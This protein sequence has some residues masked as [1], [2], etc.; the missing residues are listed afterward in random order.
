MQAVAP[1]GIEKAAEP[2]DPA[3]KVEPRKLVF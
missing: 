1:V 2:G 3:G